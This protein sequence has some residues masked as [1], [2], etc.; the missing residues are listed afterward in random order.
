MG[1]EVRVRS[2]L[3][4]GATFS[5]DVPVNLPLNPV[6]ALALDVVD[7]K[8]TPTLI[9]H[10]LLVDDNPTNLILETFVLESLGLVVTAVD[11]GIPAVKAVR[12]GRFDLVL[13]D[14]SMPDLDGLAATRRIREFISGDQLP[15]VALT[16][17]VDVQEKAA[18]LES[19]MADY[20]TKPMARDQ[21]GKAL[22]RWLACTTEQPHNEDTNQHQAV[23]SRRS[24]DKLIDPN[25][26]LE[27]VKQ[28]GRKNVDLVAG[29]VK[30]EALQRWQQL[31]QAESDADNDALRLYIHSLRSIFSSVG[32]IA[33]SEYLLEI[34]TT[35]RAGGTLRP[36]WLQSMQQLKTD[37]MIALDSALAAI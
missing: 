11:G 5:F 13:M 26:L 19:G 21:L 25:M 30:E 10:V 16:A 22:S 28:I 33:I 9:G 24:D 29:K 23:G 6:E 12:E 17:F 36:G 15:I 31:E 37:S 35:L 1:G 14:I 32:M 18:C 3:G 27:M 8:A 34:E 4:E 20:L 7:V 2:A